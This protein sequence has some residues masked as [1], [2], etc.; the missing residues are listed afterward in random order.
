MSAAS[1]GSTARL[2]GSRPFQVP[3][4]AQSLGPAPAGPESS[5]SSKV[6]LPE[7]S[8]PEGFAVNGGNP[9]LSKEQVDNIKKDKWLTVAK[10]V[11]ESSRRTFM[12]HML[13]ILSC[14]CL[15]RRSLHS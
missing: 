1:L 11:D 8:E 12:D 2:S 3:A 10:Q 5:C 15:D 14:A 13:S 9:K 6:L 4:S 7:K